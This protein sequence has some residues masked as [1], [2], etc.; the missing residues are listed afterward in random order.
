M[1]NQDDGVDKE[2]KRIFEYVDQ[3]LVVSALPEFPPAIVK[4]KRVDVLISEKHDNLLPVLAEIRFY[5]R[6]KL[7]SDEDTIAA[8][9]KLLGNDTDARTLL[10][11]SEDERKSILQKWLPRI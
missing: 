7:L 10:T 8:F 11:G 6:N 9:A 4:T 2:V 5:H 3:K 1:K